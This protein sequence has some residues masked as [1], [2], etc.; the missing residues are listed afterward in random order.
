M[1]LL[2]DVRYALRMLWKQPGFTA[3]AVLAIGL[4]ASLVMTQGMSKVP[5]GVSPTDPL[6]FGGISLLLAA[7]ALAANYFPARRAAKVDQMDALRYE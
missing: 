6:T 3:V 4:A 2:K 1:T 7:V 5:Y